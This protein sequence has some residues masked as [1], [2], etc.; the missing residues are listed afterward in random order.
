MKFLLLTLAIATSAFAQTKDEYLKQR[1]VL[2]AA[3]YPLET[4]FKK[5]QAV[6]SDLWNRSSAAE[7][8]L[9]K[10]PEVI[11]AAQAR[12]DAAKTGSLRYDEAK[13]IMDEALQTIAQWK[14]WSA[15]AKE[16]LPGL[17]KSLDIE[18]AKLAVEEAKYRKAQDDIDQ[19]EAE[20]QN[21]PEEIKNPF[22]K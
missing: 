22:K 10:A 3:R 21:Q 16:V 4:A 20:Y 13:A 17:K 14:Q 6:C 5:Q 8:T 12:Y 19:L 2:E 1:R 11:A 15:Q 18:K 9:T 7:N